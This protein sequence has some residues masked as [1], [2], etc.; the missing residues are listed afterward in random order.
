VRIFG[1]AS[2]FGASVKD[3]AAALREGLEVMATPGEANP[4]DLSDE[5]EPADTPEAVH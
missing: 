4:A 1:A 5:D 3:F 2:V